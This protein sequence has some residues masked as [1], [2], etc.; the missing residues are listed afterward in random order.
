[1]KNVKVLW[2]SLALVFMLG[3]PCLAETYAGTMSIT[4]FAGGYLF[5]SKESLENKP[6]F[7]LRLG[8]DFSRN[9]GI[10]AAGDYLTTKS[11]ADLGDATVYGGRLEALYYY[12]PDEKLVPYFAVGAGGRSLKYDDFSDLDRGHFLVDWGLG[13]KYSLSD[14]LALRADIRHMILINDTIQNLEATLGISY[15]IGGD[16][17]APVVEEVA[18]VVVEPA[19]APAP[20]PVVEPTP[21]PV[22]MPVVPVPAPTVMEKEIIE[23]GRATLD[24]KFRTNKADIQPQYH[25]ELA[26]FATVMKK[27]PDL[28][29]VI[30]GHTDN[31]G[32]A[33]FNQ[34]LSQ[35]RADS[36]KRYMTEKFGI[37]ASR[38]K[39]KG[40]GLS[41]PIAS[42]AT[43]AGKA[44]N[45][46]V[47]AVVEYMD[48]K[49]IK[50]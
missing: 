39:A 47:E 30:E 25:A 45:R 2:L 14:S 34:K 43:A 6:V 10:E 11:D 27:H 31:V 44:K 21:A 41:M 16:K 42:N 17:P 3:V 1:M 15:L 22:P 24:I 4:P 49:I 32:S 18:P 46:R 37:D 7:G 50:E 23:K 35:R 29:V 13:V 9:W 33:P 28:K 36:V 38:L 48:K 5:Q 19:P 12:A 40:Y 26:E 8:Y 20:A